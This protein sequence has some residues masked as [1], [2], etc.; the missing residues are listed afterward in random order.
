ME[1][2]ATMPQLAHMIHA[3]PTLAEGLQEAIEDLEGKAIHQVRK[4]S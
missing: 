2:G 4:K 3:H 1:T